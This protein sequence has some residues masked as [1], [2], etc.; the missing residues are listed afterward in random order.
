MCSIMIERRRVLGNHPSLSIYSAMK[1]QWLA[2]LLVA[3]ALPVSAQIPGPFWP[4]SASS[5]PHHRCTFCARD[6]HGHILRSPAARRAF[7]A[8][9]SCPSTGLTQGACPGYQ[10]DHIKPLHLGGPD[11]PSN[12]QLALGRGT[13]AEDGRRALRYCIDTDPTPG[14]GRNEFFAS[15]FGQ[16]SSSAGSCPGVGTAV[17][18]GSAPR[19][20]SAPREGASISDMSS[21]T[22]KRA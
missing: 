3:L 18:G 15:A 11:D 10:V 4:M 19:R 14:H 20:T 7:R 5:G 8:A 22:S 13:S 21:R 17:A 6:A 2:A 9:N 16:A 1:G 12:M